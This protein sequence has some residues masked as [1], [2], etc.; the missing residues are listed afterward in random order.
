MSTMTDSLTKFNWQPQPAAQAVLDSIILDFLAAC[1]QAAVLAKRM[2]EE[3]GTRFK[4][5]ID[6]IQLPK[7]SGLEAKMR[8]VGYSLDPQAGAAQC[9]FHH[10]AM[11]PHVL[12]VAG[13]PLVV[14]IKVDCVADFVA[15]WGLHD[16]KIVGEPLSQFRLATVFSSPGA[17][18]A[19]VER[20]GYRGFVPAPIDANKGIASLRHL[21]AFRTR[22]R[23][24]PDDHAGYAHAMKLFDAAAAEVGRDWAADLFFWSEREFWQRRNR[25]AQVQKARQDKL[26]LGW[27]NHDHHTY[28]CSRATFKEHVALFE[29]MGFHCRESFYAGAEAGWGA[30]VMEAPVGGFTTFNDVDMSPEELLGDFSHEGFSQDSGKLGTVGIWCE[31]HGQALLQAGMHHLECQFDHHALVE[32]LDREAAIKTM[33]P[34][35]TFPYLRQAFTHGE[36]WAIKPERAN[37]L[38]TAGL[39]TAEQCER[40]IKDG[41]LG[42]HM[43]NLER[44]DGFKG[45]NQQGV[46]D[47]IARTDPRRRPLAAGA[48]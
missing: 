17:E 7:S 22:N 47:I 37:K 3:T 33:A 38:L 30:Q 25:A 20:H 13:G 15:C 2:K 43:E 29:K 11:F 16:V 14:A 23:D 45:F 36:Q 21:E 6:F 35:T 28:R 12:F 24:L 39:I 10:G 4:D 8:E 18:L 31:L 41:A 26:G 32:Q 44:N 42:S 9:Y 46:S 27:A 19:V 34:F 1:P 5:W 40:F 48:H